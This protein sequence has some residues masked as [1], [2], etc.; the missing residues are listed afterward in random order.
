MAL[1][2]YPSVTAKLDAAPSVAAKV[3]LAVR[4]VFAGNLFDL[5]AAATA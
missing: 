1:S 2:Q 3:E 5:G 4:S